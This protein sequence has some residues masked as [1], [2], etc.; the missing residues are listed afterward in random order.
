MVATDGHRRV[1]PSRELHQGVPITS[2][3]MAPAR[4]MYEFKIWPHVTIKIIIVSQRVMSLSKTSRGHNPNKYCNLVTVLCV[5]SSLKDNCQIYSRGL[6]ISLTAWF[7]G[8]SSSSIKAKI[9]LATLPWFNFE[10]Q[11]KKLD[12]NEKGQT[13]ILRSQN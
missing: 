13:T 3:T 1:N 9:T 6:L 2:A 8:L 5:R 4:K 11:G 12:R 10:P 7:L